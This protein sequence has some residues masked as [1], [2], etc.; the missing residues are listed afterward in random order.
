ML[1]LT[2]PSDFFVRT[3]SC[4]PSPWR[5]PRPHRPS[6]ASPT[7]STWVA[8]TTAMSGPSPTTKTR[9]ATRRSLTIR[10]NRLISAQNAGTDCTAKVLQNKT[11][12]WG[13]SY[14]YDPWGNLIGKSVTKCSAENLA[15][16][17]LV[18]NQLSGYGYDVAGN[19]TADVTEG[20]SAVYD[21]IR[22]AR[23]YL[24]PA[25]LRSPKSTLVQKDSR[26]GVGE[27]DDGSCRV[28]ISEGREANLLRRRLTQASRNV[29]T[30]NACALRVSA[31]TLTFNSRSA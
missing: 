15:L 4:S 22:T 2:N 28:K 27:S 16:T 18:K 13:N 23:G 11:E 7:T 30:L 3:S 1:R 25:S 14:S 6:S 17:A 26:C 8:A 29:P 19:M 12:Y 9:P 21:P 5:P 20:V 31:A 10:L 24:R